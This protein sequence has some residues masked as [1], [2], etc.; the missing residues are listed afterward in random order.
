MKLLLIVSS[1]HAGG[2]ERV[3]STLV[4][5][6]AA[7]GDEVTLLITYS[8]RGEC[9]YPLDERVRVVWLADHLAR[10]HSILAPLSRLITLRRIIK[11]SG[12]NLAISFLTNVNVASIVATRGLNL[13][14]IVCE[15]TNPSIVNNVGWLLT[16]L[17]QLTYRFATRVN[18]QAVPTVFGL[19][20]MVPAMRCVDVIPNPLPAELINHSTFADVVASE[21]KIKQVVAMGRLSADKQF[22]V[23][24]EVFSRVAQ[25]YP[26]WQLTI[27]GDGPERLALEAQVLQLGLQARVKLPG[28]TK[29]AWQ[30]LASGQ[31][32][33]MTSRVEGFPNVLLEAMALG[34]PC[35]TYDCPSGPAEL[36]ESGISG[37]LI[38]MNDKEG[39]VQALKQLMD[40]A[41]SRSE[42]GQRGA[43]SVKRRYAIAKVID[44]WDAVFDRIQRDDSSEYRS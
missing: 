3:A 31:I 41:Q 26:D 17:R 11:K 35:I 12:A 24:I 16:K 5:A 32:F 42:L 10:N 15:R 18:V 44:D 40:D 36:T 1:M 30:S 9:V 25:A 43:E 8:G 22:D 28:R 29:Q 21:L 13:P 33:G 27:W 34:L 6:W 7:R 14:L 37:Y 23:L 19:R 4:N 20:S 38:G 2:A 39:F